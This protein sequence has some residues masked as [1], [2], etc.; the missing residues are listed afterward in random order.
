MD[1][2]AWM[3]GEG[4]EALGVG[5]LVETARGAGPGLDGAGQY[6]A[7][8]RAQLS[9][10]LAAY[11]LLLLKR[12]TDPVIWGWTLTTPRPEK[13]ADGG[14]GRVRVTASVCQV[15]RPESLW[16]AAGGK[17][18]DES[19]CQSEAWYGSQDTVAETMKKLEEKFAATKK[20]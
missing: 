6:A 8:Q 20:A 4:F 11:Q 16:G 15:E 5:P 19:V 3:W 18:A 9:L 10:D 14:N 17:G 1:V 2:V 7:A 13:T 12:T